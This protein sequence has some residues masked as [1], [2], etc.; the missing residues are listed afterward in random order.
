MQGIAGAIDRF[1]QAFGPIAGGG[2]THRRLQLRPERS[3]PPDHN[4]RSSSLQYPLAAATFLM[5]GGDGSG[6]SQL[7]GARFHPDLQ[8]LHEIDW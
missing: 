7:S 8:H 3:D 4:V 6:T 2:L 1:G 5:E